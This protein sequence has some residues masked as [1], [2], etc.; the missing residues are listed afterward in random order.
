MIGPTTNPLESKRAITICAAVV[1]LI[2]LAVYSLTLAPTVT[3]VDSG[4]LIVA[5]YGLGVAHPPG[6]PLYTLL[7][8]AA[9]LVPIG[10]VA[11]RVN[12]ASAIFAAMA[13]AALTLV[14]AEALL[15]ASR[16]SS[17]NVNGE[18]K[19]K[20]GKKKKQAAKIEAGREGQIEKPSSFALVA[21]LVAG[22][23]FAFSR[24]LW[25]YATIAEVYTLNAL[26]M[27]IIFLLMLRW[28]RA[29]ETESRSDGWL[30]AAALVFGLALGVH[31][32]TIG[33]MLPA[34]AFLVYRTEGVKFFT[35]RR[36]LYA[37]LCAFAGLAVYIYLPIAAS[38]S[39]L[40]NWGNPGT[41]E[42]F[43][44]HVT[45]WQYQT[46]IDFSLKTMMSQLP[47][48]G[49]LLLREFGPVWLPI[50][51]ALALTGMV[52]SFKRDRVVFWFLILVIASDLI[53]ALSYEIAEDKDAYYLPVFIALAIAAGFGAEWIIKSTKAARLPATI[54]RYAFA[55]LVFIV[56]VVALA[57]NLPF[58][59]RS[60]YFIAK[61]YVENVFKT[62]G[63]NGMVLTGD[64][65]L[66]SPMFYL[67]QVEGHRADVVA[68][69]IR[70]LRRS[71]YFDYLRRAYPRLIEATSEKVDLFLEDLI[72]WERNPDLYNPAPSAFG[73][74]TFQQW[75]QNPEMYAGRLTPLERINFHFIDMMLS[76]VSNHLKTAPVYISHDIVAGIEPMLITE[77]NAA[78]QRVPQ[79][80]VF[81]LVT[82]RAFY[83]PVEPQF[84]MR[85]LTDGTIK[86]E[87]DDTAMLKVLPVYWIMHYYRGAYLAQHNRHEEAVEAYRQALELSPDNAQI[88]QS[89]NASLSALRMTPQ[90][91]KN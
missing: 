11:A 76:F 47:Q 71:W 16:L 15:A 58:N 46:N 7:A 8:H 54:P 83:D 24:T 1:F 75:K 17:R 44:W 60:R 43:V 52:A 35:S 78:Y 62:V 61:D 91:R 50:G 25:A 79:G 64:W 34:L 42:R 23:L 74:L 85:G 82:D 66:Y 53:Y 57:G 21:C 48:F 45:G 80:L 49:A 37:A 19:S 81:E 18:K 68:I 20:R 51:L 33:L 10:E 55:A 69:D 72:G 77:L 84:V 67:Q 29:I 56:P 87:K 4:E 90:T 86:F 88:K 13:S 9:T 22:L 38:R 14:V 70:L 63:Q 31:H 2:A 65:Q 28:R 12:F 26:L 73:Q 36:L 5:A 59:N 32:V 41:L 40:M 6:F 27:L 89:L 3:L 30:Y 39:P